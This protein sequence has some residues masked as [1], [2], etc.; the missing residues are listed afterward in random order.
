[1]KGN[2]QTEPHTGDFPTLAALSV[3]SSLAGF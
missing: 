2:N 1:M 3:D